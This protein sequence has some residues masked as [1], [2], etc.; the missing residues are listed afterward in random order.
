MLVKLV[1]QLSHNHLQKATAELVSNAVRLCQEQVIG[2]VK[3]LIQ[4]LISKQSPELALDAAWAL[5]EMAHN[6]PL[7]SGWIRDAGGQ[8]A[9]QE[10]LVVYCSHREHVDCCIW[11]LRMIGGVHGLLQLLQTEP[12]PAEVLLALLQVLRK[13]NTCWRNNQGPL[14]EA[15]QLLR[16][17]AQR[18]AQCGQAPPLLQEA[19]ALLQEM[20]LEPLLGQELLVMGGTQLMSLTLQMAVRCQDVETARSCCNILCSLAKVGRVDSQHYLRTTEVLQALQSAAQLGSG[21]ELEVSVGQTLG[22]ILGLPEAI[23]LFSGLGEFAVQGVLRA[24]RELCNTEDVE[25]IRLLP[26]M[27]GELLKLQK[28]TPFTSCIHLALLDALGSC[29]SSLSPHLAPGACAEL[30]EAVRLIASRLHEPMKIPEEDQHG[31]S[32]REQLELIFDPLGKVTLAKDAWRDALLKHGAKE[33]TQQRILELVGDR[34]LEKYCVWL[35]AALAGMPFVVQELQKHLERPEV[36]DACMCAIIDILDDDLDCDWLLS[37]RTLMATRQEVPGLLELIAQAMTAHPQDAIVQSRGCH[38]L[39]LLMRMVPH[40]GELSQA[41]LEIILKTVLHAYNSHYQ[42]LSAVRDIS[43]LLRSLL[44]PRN[45][46][47]AQ[48]SWAQKQLAQHLQQEF[49]HRQLE[50]SVKHFAGFD[51]AYRCGELFENALACVAL[52]SGAGRMMNFLMESEEL[53]GHLTLCISGFKA[54]FELAGSRCAVLGEANGIVLEGHIVGQGCPGVQAALRRLV[55]GREDEQLRQAAVLL[56][57]L[58]EALKQA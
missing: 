30:D 43:F 49:T 34:R 10:S 33:A 5:N 25:A 32:W 13:D 56:D 9:L 27:V 16:C 42:H 41:C 23:Q 7:V 1:P 44:E 48:A 52:L 55:Q 47:E 19:S 26:Q 38:C 24:L 46:Q 29:C 54:L 58:C 57:G 53:P 12:L 6:N 50:S 36:V 15:P 28:K 35:L 20:S 45:G 17:C 18:L 22:F 31:Y 3:L 14:D 39:V 2:C 40:V 8:Q 21:Q 11:L 4:A 37:G 51:D